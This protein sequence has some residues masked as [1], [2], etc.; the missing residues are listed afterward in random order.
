MTSVATDMTVM[1]LDEIVGDLPL[2]DR[3]AFEKVFHVSTTRG[4]LVMPE[5]MHSWVVERFGN[6]DLVRQ[7]KII[8]VTNLATLEGVLFN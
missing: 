1:R 2:E 8:K 7:Q 3:L 4:E 5:S 6:I